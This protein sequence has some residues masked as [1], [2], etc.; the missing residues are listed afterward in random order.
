[1]IGT[2]AY[3]A[4]EQADGRAAG[5]PADLYSLAL[6]LYEGFAGENPLRGETVAATALPTRRRDP[7]ARRACARTCRRRCARRSTARSTPAPA[8]RGTLAQ[9][10]GALDEAR[11]RAPRRGGA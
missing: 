10:R 4:P 1:M 2:L 11:F 7:A 8:G 9:L 5:P 3:M 6:T